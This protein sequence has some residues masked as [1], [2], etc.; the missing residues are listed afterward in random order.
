M[1][2]IHRPH[3]L[4]DRISTYDS[5]SLVS[6]EPVREDGNGTKCVTGPLLHM[7]SQSQDF[8]H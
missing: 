4:I 2:C 3:K 8:Q 7:I 5:S 1:S 6:L